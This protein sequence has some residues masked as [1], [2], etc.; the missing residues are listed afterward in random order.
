MKINLTRSVPLKELCRISARGYT[1]NIAESIEF[2]FSHEA[3]V[4]FATELLWLYD[5]INENR[6]LDLCTRQLRV[7]SAPNQVLGFYLTPSSPM[8]MIVVNSL[9]REDSGYE[10]K[11]WKEIYM[12]EKNIN[13]HYE[14][15]EPSNEKDGLLVVEPYELRWKNII[16]ITIFDGEKN[17]ITKYHDTVIFEINY[18]GIKELATMLLVWAYN[19]KEG[20][21]Y[22]LSRIGELVCGYNLGVILTKDSIPTTFK[23]HDLGSAYDYDPRF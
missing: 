18:E 8:L 7:D 21:E 13:Q 10:Y 19:S 9:K 20:D 4:G 14:I 3:I 1:T 11:N 16:N 5:D 6:K 12:K 23:C 22:L 2:T 17:D 15:R